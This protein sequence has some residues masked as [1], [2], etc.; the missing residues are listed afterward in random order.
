MK[1]QRRAARC[2]NCG[3]ESTGKFCDECG[4]VQEARVAERQDNAPG[5][6]RAA[7]SA[8]VAVV[9]VASF[10]IGRLSSPGTGEAD[11]TP[12]AVR[13]LAGLAAM[14][15]QERVSQLYD[16]VMRYGEAGRVDSARLLAPSAILAY[17]ALGPLDAHARYDIGMIRVVTGDSVTARAQADTILRQ[18][19][20]HLLGLVLAL[21]TAREPNARA[22]FA[23]RLALANAAES[24]NPLPGYSDHANDVKRALA[25]AVRTP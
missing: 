4:T 1:R 24:A 8:A 7:L 19:P 15:P 25:A 10:F 6:S 2:P 21:R 9:A 17:E 20:S 14:P 16:Q 12:L 13:P 3:T 18:R 5:I 23:K 22:A 11:G